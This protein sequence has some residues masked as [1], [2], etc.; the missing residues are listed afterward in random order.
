MAVSLSFILWRSLL[1]VEETR[2]PGENYW[3]VA[4][5]W[6]IMLY[7]VHLA[8]NSIRLVS[9]IL[10]FNLVCI[11]EMQIITEWR[12]VQWQNIIYLNR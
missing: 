4:S 7:R 1:L 5:Y 8:M 10:Y 2:V 12:I 11:D 3:S 6:H 9:S